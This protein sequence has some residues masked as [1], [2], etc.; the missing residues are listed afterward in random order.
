MPA[1]FRGRKTQKTKEYYCI[2]RLLPVLWL[3]RRLAG[4]DFEVFRSALKIYMNDVGL[5]CALENT[6][7]MSILDTAAF[8]RNPKAR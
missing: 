8:F 5:L 3:E 4:S 7:A 2:L 1:D 6:N